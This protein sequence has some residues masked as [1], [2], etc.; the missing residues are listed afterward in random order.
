MAEPLA[1]PLRGLL[2]TIELVLGH[3]EATAGPQ[4]VLD[5]DY[6]WSV[7]PEDRYGVYE[8]PSEFTVGQLSECLSNIAAVA[9]RGDQTAVY[10]LVWVGEVLQALGEQLSGRPIPPT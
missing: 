3:L 9:E 4:V 7:P 8:E 5:H 10:A 6:F 2:T 1:V